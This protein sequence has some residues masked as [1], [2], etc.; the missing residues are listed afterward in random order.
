[1]SSSSTYSSA[2]LDTKLF[3][4]LGDMREQ[5]IALQSFQEKNATNEAIIRHLTKQ[6]EKKDKKIK[7]L[8]K[9]CHSAVCPSNAVDYI[10]IPRTPRNSSHPG[11]FT[12]EP[13][14][15]RADVPFDAYRSDYQGSRLFVSDLADIREPLSPEVLSSFHRKKASSNKEVDAENSRSQSD[16]TD[17]IPAIRAA[18]GV[19]EPLSMVTADVQVASMGICNTDNSEHVRI[20]L[21]E[22]KEEFHRHTGLKGCCC[23]ECAFG[24]SPDEVAQEDD[25]ASDVD[26]LSVHSSN[27]EDQELFEEDAQTAPD[28]DVQSVQSDLKSD[29]QEEEHVPEEDE[30]VATPEEAE[31]AAVDDEALP[32]EADAPTV[33][34]EEEDAP[35]EEAE[36]EDAPI[37]EAEEE[38]TLVIVFYK[39]K[40]YCHDTVTDEIFDLIPNPD[41]EGEIDPENPDEICGPDVVG[42]WVDGK[43]VLKSEKKEKKVKSSK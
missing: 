43:I 26:Y 24:P 38:D 34:A 23:N 27:D 7:K 25:G 40:Q 21:D 8:K 5:T 32:E 1:M 6:L 4:I 28:N 36:E 15:Q 33:E 42:M 22:R 9:K 16:D 13:K 19:T 14:S 20:E 35:T 41:A 10:P 30:R 31:E 11:F 29:I 18:N 39:G 37:E 2:S 17:M 3:T 12:P